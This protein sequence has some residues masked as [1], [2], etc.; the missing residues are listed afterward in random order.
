MAARLAGLVGMMADRKADRKAALTGLQLV[1]LKVAWKVVP[2]VALKGELKAAWM[3]N[4]MVA[5][6]VAV[7]DLMTAE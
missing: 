7:M 6:L 4:S 5:H 3:A 2:M 1:A